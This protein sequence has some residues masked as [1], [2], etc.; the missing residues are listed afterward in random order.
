[1]Q[2]GQ[3]LAIDIF[4]EPRHADAVKAGKT[5]NMRGDRAVRINP[6]VL[7]QKTDTRQAEPIDFLLLFGGNRALDPNEAL[8]GAEALPQLSRVDVWKHGG[9]KFDRFILIDDSPGLRENRHN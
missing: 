3:S 6:F 8:A 2:I 7:G 4:F 5:K 9:Q 1:M